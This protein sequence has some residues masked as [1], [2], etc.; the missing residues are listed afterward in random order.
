[1]EH[2]EARLIIPTR[3]EGYV[4]S[5]DYQS[6]LAL[7]ERELIQAFGGFTVTEGRGVWDSGT[8]I[9][10]ESVRV[11]L[12]YF[13]TDN[14]IATGVFESLRGWVKSRLNQK[15]MYLSRTVIE[16]NPIE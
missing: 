7:L 16:S 4:T 3:P 9:I 13:N 14:R 11:Y 1:M 15:A 8:S 6:E 10:T 12:F 2:I 5:P